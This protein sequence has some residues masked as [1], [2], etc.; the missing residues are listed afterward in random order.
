MIWN[1]EIVNKNDP[2]RS[3]IILLL[4]VFYAH[5]TFFRR[6]SLLGFSFRLFD[7]N[8]VCHALNYFIQFILHEDAGISL[9]S[10]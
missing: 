6:V 3:K 1:G 2:K 8:N 4:D 10:L 9:D 5:L 7:M